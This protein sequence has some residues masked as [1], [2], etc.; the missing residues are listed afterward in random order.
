[1]I[2]VCKPNFYHVFIV[3]RDKIFSC[4]TYLIIYLFF[5]II[6]TLTLTLV[7]ARSKHKFLKYQ[8]EALMEWYKCNVISK[9]KKILLFPC[10]N[11]SGFKM[12]NANLKINLQTSSYIRVKVIFKWLLKK[13]LKKSVHFFFYKKDFYKKMSLKN[14]PKHQENVKKIPRLKCLSCNF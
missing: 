9:L 3:T 7:I 1:M 14:P 6:F 12:K 11:Q 4:T 5:T 8:Q 2:Y 10:S 13:W